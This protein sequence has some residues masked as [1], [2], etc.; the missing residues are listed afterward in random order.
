MDC[1]PPGPSSMGFSRQEYW[2]GVPLQKDSNVHDR[3][4]VASPFFVVCVFLVFSTFHLFFLFYSL[5]LGYWHLVF[6]PVS[7]PDSVRLSLLCLVAYLYPTLCNPMNYS[8]PGSSVHGDSPG[9]NTGVGCRRLE[10]KNFSVVHILA[11]W[12]VVLLSLGNNRV[13]W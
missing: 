1:S 11:A 12:L 13:F 2:S 4:S 7:V 3:G 10:V 9:K 8:P 5:F 6:A